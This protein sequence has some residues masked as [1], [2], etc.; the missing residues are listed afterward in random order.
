M[1]TSYNRSPF[2]GWTVGIG[3]PAAVVDATFNR[4]LFYTILFGVVLIGAGIALAWTFSTR[5][6]GSIQALATMARDLGL[7]KESAALS[8]VGEKNIATPIVEIETLR[9]AFLNAARLI[10]DRANE[11]DR[12]ESSLRRV[13]QRL[14]LAQEAANIGSF[15]RDLQTNAVEWS[16]SM[17]KLFGLPRGGFSGTYADF[18]KLVHPDDIVGIERAM[19]NSIATS[20][21]FEVE[22]RVM[23]SDGAACWMASRGRIISD[24]GSRR[25]IGVNIDITARKRAE[26]ELRQLIAERQAAE[27]ALREADRRKDEFLAMLGHELR[28]PL[29]VISTSLELLRSSDEGEAESAELHEMVTAQIAHMVRLVDDLLDVSRITHGNIRL[30]LKPCDLTALARD[31]LE[32]HRGLFDRSGLSLSADLPKRPLWVLGDW[33]RLKQV[34]GNGLQNAIKFTDRGGTVAVTL[35]KAE[36]ENTAVLSIRDT[37]VGIDEEML[38]RAFEPFSQAESGVRRSSGGLGLGL[39]VVKGL[40]DLHNGNVTLRS[41]GIGKGAEL[42]IRLPLTELAPAKPE[43]E[44]RAEPTGCSYRILLIEDNVMGARTMRL[45]LTRLGHEV[46]VAHTGR[47]GIQA[48]RRFDPQVVLCDIGLPD[49]DGF[50]VARSLREE[51]VTAGAYLIALSGYGQAEYQRKALE[52]G[53]NLHLTKPV[54]IDHLTELLKCAEIRQLVTV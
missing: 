23:R 43:C 14:E 10:Q 49:L 52:A 30:E 1:Y 34:I 7:G 8:A 40:I 29:N 6:A 4:S 12:V 53:F 41:A 36:G 5:S 18:R 9:E 25:V 51:S 44:T 20:S 28:N 33:T 16:A 39:A 37:G 22:Y 38:T 26:E 31:T 27:H 3:V 19:Q 11:R 46:E 32:E 47:E 42:T 50:A 35:T 24:K 48:A 17:E 13:S 45:L 21:P 15:E 2:S 54:H